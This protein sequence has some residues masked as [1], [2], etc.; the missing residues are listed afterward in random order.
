MPRIRSIKPDFFMDDGLA[1]LPPLTRI[2]F[3]GLWTLSDSEGR[4]QDAPRRIRALVLPYDDCDVDA[5][6]TALH[7]KFI[8]RYVVNGIRLIQV[9]NFRKHQR[10]SGKEAETPSELP[11]P[12]VCE[13]MGKQSGSN[14]EAVNVLERKGK[15]GKGKEL[16]DSSEP[17]T[18][19]ASEPPIFTIP[20][21]GDGL[22]EWPLMQEKVRE[23]AGSYPGVDVVAEIR[24]AKQWILDNRP[25]AKT[26]KGM[27][28]FINRWLSKA[29]DNQKGVRNGNIGPI[30][31]GD[32]VVGFAKP[33]E[34]KYSHITGGP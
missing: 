17:E 30:S 5:M 14:G 11:P 3:A 7:P 33:V 27:P 25:R 4:L 12:P 19:P 21:V 13:A 26:F 6:L 15:E 9:N 29:Q 28:S 31:Q 18:T 24:K 20:C 34:G 23:W 22:K 2:L 32:R 8:R 1:D 16:K 10:I